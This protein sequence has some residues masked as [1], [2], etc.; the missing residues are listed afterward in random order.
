M[1][2]DL[3]HREEADPLGDEQF[4]QPEQFLGEHDKTERRQADAKRRK[5]LT[6]DI[7][8]EDGVQH[9]RSAVEILLDVTDAAL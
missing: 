9:N 8:I 4:H 2:E 3:Q 6:K 7:A 1:G 5:E